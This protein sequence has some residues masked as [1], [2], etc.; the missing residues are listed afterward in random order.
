MKAR[1]ISADGKTMI[2]QDVGPNDRMNI[3]KGVSLLDEKVYAAAADAAGSEDEL[4]SA[5][6]VTK[7]D[8]M[9]LP[10]PQL[11]LRCKRKVQKQAEVA[12]A[13]KYS[14]FEISLALIAGAGKPAFDNL[15]ADAIEY[16]KALKAAKD[17]IE[18]ANDADTAVAVSFVVP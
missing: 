2:E 16:R 9:S 5:L 11:K 7:S 12:F 1:I 14:N 8:D 6:G 13:A 18:A 15:K 4:V 10:L 17:A 3:G